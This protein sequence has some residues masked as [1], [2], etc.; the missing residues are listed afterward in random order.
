MLHTLADKKTCDVLGL[1]LINNIFKDEKE[2]HFHLVKL[3]QVIDLYN[4]K[5]TSKFNNFT[6]ETTSRNADE[7]LTLTSKEESIKLNQLPPW[8]EEKSEKG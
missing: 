7:V 4:K 6:E 1:G 3:K 2:A 8:C 5:E